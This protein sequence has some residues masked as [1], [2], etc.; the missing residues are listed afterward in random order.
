MDERQEEMESL[1]PRIYP[2]SILRHFCGPVQRFDSG[3]RD[4]LDEML[5]PMKLKKGVL[6]CDCGQSVDKPNGRRIDA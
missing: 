3:P 2:D 5:R 4:L 1:S 6:I